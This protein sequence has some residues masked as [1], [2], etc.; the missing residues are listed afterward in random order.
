MITEVK[1]IPDAVP[2]AVVT[3]IDLAPS[4]V[5]GGESKVTP[6]ALIDSNVAPFVPAIVTPL[7]VD[8]FVPIIRN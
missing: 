5:E 6:D 8:R 7:V 3:T 1:V 4:V 2:P